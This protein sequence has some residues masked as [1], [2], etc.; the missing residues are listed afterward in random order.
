MK[1]KSTN[2]WYMVGLIPPLWLDCLLG[3]S[4]ARNKGWLVVVLG[5]VMV[6]GS[7]WIV[8]KFHNMPRSEASYEPLR[9]LTIE[10]PARYPVKLYACD[11]MAKF[12]FMA[13]VAEVISPFRMKEDHYKLAVNPKLIEQHGETFIKI[14]ATR[15]MRRYETKGA[16]KLLLGL[17]VPL[18]IILAIV[19]AIFVSRVDLAQYFSAFFITF[20]LP[21]LMV[22]LVVG[23]LFLWNRFVSQQ[24]IKLDAFLTSYFSVRDV[25]RYI[26]TMEKIEEGGEKE[27]SRK[28]SEHYAQ[29]RIQN[30]RKHAAKNASIYDE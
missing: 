11:D 1:V 16:L 29:E 17:L 23:D 3:M 14:A 4:L 12:D 8:K 19:L 6:L 21:L 28:F 27:K 13:R 22:F 24:D 25:E 15:E 18:Q 9:L 26:T 2:L 20:L 30:L 5:A 10:L 7:V